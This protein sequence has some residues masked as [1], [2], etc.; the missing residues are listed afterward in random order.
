MET[1]VSASFPLRAQSFALAVS[2]LIT[3][4]WRTSSPFAVAPMH[5]SPTTV[6]ATTTGTRHVRVAARGARGSSDLNAPTGVV[7]PHRPTRPPQPEGGRARR[8]AARRSRREEPTR[9]LEPRTPFTTR[10]PRRLSLVASDASEWLHGGALGGMRVAGLAAG[11]GWCVAHPLPPISSARP[12]RRGSKG[13]SERRL[14][15]GR[16]APSSS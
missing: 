1:T 13:S 7:S 15:A 16:T 2:S 8:A 11:A 6:V 5:N 12:S 14:Y 10:W 4:T 9:G 3:R